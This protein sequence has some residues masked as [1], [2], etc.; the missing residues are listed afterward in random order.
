MA[1]SAVTARSHG[2]AV[3]GLILSLADNKRLLGMR[4]AEWILGAPELEA[5]I[6]CASMAQDEWGHA[7]L[8][9]SLLREFDDDLERLEHG[10]PPEEYASMEALDD[11][12][13]D[14]P[15]L[16]V[17]NAFVD[18]ALS[19]QLE[20]LRRSAH[21]PL[22]QRVEKMLDEERFHGAHGVAWLRRLAGPDATRAA[23]APA[24]R[25]AVA[26]ALRWFGPAGGPLEELAEAGVADAGPEEL[27]ARYLARV[28]PLLDQLGMVAGDIAIDFD[29]FDPARRRGAGGP[30]E[31]TLVR[32][33][34]DRNRAFLM[35]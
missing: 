19:V 4:Y 12:P 18:A 8:L 13:A 27:R 32:V 15:G 31:E 20:A 21:Q 14:W 5:G 3:R 26:A 23:V 33:R 9:Y 25:A 35:D 30:D 17:L 10:R 22:R 29:D 34:G 16:V 11:A 6:A 2:T 7:R 1:E 24:A 28:Q